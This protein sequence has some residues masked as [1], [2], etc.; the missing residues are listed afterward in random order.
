VPLATPQQLEDVIGQLRLAGMVQIPEDRRAARYA[1]M[2]AAAAGYIY[3]A[4]AQG[5]FVVPFDLTQIPEGELR[6][7]TAAMLTAHTCCL[8]IWYA[9]PQVVDAPEGLKKAKS[10]ADAFLA[11]LAKGSAILGGLARQAPV[12]TQGR[13]GTAISGETSD[14]LPSSWFA[15]YRRPWPSGPGGDLFRNM[16]GGD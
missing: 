6:T 14:G 11:T 12:A 5:G 1:D 4:A 16:R 2:L 9:L 10:E 3:E 13:V 8:A 15:A 7:S